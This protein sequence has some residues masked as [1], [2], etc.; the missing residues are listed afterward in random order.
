MVGIQSVAM[1]MAELCSSMPTS[2]GLYY[3]AAVL[4]PPRWGPYAAWNTGWSNWLVQITGAPSVNYGTAAMT[5]AAAS[6]RNPNY[7]PTDWET[8]LL[9]AFLMLIHG[10]MSSMP[11][12]WLAKTNSVG[13]IINIIFLC[14]VV[15]LIPA[16]TDRVARGES[17]FT[18]SSEVW[19]H[20]YPGTD[21]PLGVG[22]LMSFVAVI[23]TM[24]GYDAPFHL[25]E[26]CSNANIA[27]PRAIV[28]TSAIGGIFGWFLQLVVAY[29]VVD[30]E[31]ALDSDLGQPFAAYLTQC[32]PQAI[33]EAILAMTIVAGF[34]MGQG[35]M[36]AASRVTFAYA[37]DDCF[38]LSKY[39]KKVNPITQTPVNAV[40]FNVTIGI[41]LDLLIL[42]GPLVAGALFSIG[43]IAAFVAFTIPIFIRVF[44]VGNR[45]RRGPWHLGKFSMPLGV[46]ACSFVALM[47]PILCLPSS[48]GADLD[49]ST[50]NW[51]R[52]S[53]F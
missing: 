46:I 17:K 21:F 26:E 6:I 50:M 53:S 14:I 40:W 34:F 24:S 12:R 28:M 23:W 52:L 11:T 5:L 7:V 41:C 35:C 16:A 47:V 32:M 3:A 42:G 39:W 9:T 25:S 2:G 19:G 30:I 45:F 22:V 44:F 15:I 36:I 31:A 10:V 1:S 37:R 38:P 18:K 48:T 51:V 4:A 20:I 13:T 49:P 29:T 33:T 8:F 27:S 43:A